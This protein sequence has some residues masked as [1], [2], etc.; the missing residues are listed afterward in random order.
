[1]RSRRSVAASAGPSAS[2]PPEVG[3]VDDLEQALDR[4]Y[5]VEPEGFV[6]ERDRLSRELRDAGKREDAK[7]V[8]D[9]RKPS[10]SAWTVNQLARQERREIDLLLDASHRLREAQQ[11]L[12]AGKDQRSFDEARQTQ[13]DALAGLRRAAARILDEAGRGGEATLNRVVATLQAGAASDEGREL[14]ARGRLTGDLEATGF[15]LLTPLAGKPPSKRGRP[16]ATRSAKQPVAPRKRAPQ[17]GERKREQRERLEE[18]RSRLRD[19]QA[20]AKDVEADLRR[21]EQDADKAG[22]D[23]ARAKERLRKTQA[24]AAQARKAVEHAEQ[25]LRE[26]RQKR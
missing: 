19:A 12:L 7:L 25:G 3:R 20:T 9:H 13:R 8:K 22:R 4:L 21:A 16:T 14:L 18:A 15:E 23:L 6:A 1:V 17:V 2:P 24:S 26:A 11:G 5:A 10:L